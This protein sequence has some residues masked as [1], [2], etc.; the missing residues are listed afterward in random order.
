MS[1]VTRK[2][3]QDFL[4]AGFNRI[5][6]G[7]QSFDLKYLKWMGRR[8]DRYLDFE[9]LK[10]LVSPLVDENINFGL[11]LICGFPNQ[12]TRELILDCTK[13]LS[14]RPK[15]ISLYRLV[16]DEATP[17]SKRFNGFTSKELSCL[18]ESELKAGE[19][20]QRSSYNHYEI[21]NYALD[22]YES[23]H[24][25]VYWNMDN[26]LALGEGGVSTLLYDNGKMGA[27]RVT[28]LSGNKFDLSFIDRDEFR[29]ENMMMGLRTATGINLKKFKMRFGFTPEYFYKEQIMQ[30]TIEGL[31]EQDSTHF[32]MSKKGFD[33]LNSF[34]VKLLP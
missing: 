30:A 3:L 13:A 23:K 20:L 16:L 4:E 24:N 11:D 1:S 18:D 26:S 28:N 32:K 34:L 15:H 10:N 19:F 31:I 27:A 7:V 8:G 33:Y 2:R 5:T 17:L 25:L 6:F 9:E 14:L 12:T 21:S 22:G 29:F